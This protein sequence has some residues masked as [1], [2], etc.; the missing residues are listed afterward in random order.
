[1]VE[2]I[3]RFKWWLFALILLGSL[4]TYYER[5]RGHREHS[6]D[7]VIA[8]AAA[9]YGLDAALIK[10]VVWRESWFNPDARGT[11]GEL[12][13]MQL[14]QAA[15]AEWAGAE[16]LLW[17][18]HAQLLD[19]AKNTLAGTWYLRKQLRRFPQADNPIPYALAAYNAGPT[20]AQ[21]WSK[22]AA[23][24]NSAAFLRQIDFPGTKDY[25]L[26]VMR[27]QERY[28]RDFPA[29]TMKRENPPSPSKG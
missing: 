19:P 16:H 25:V 1:M 9:R 11:S 15:A 7:A 12:G 29:R 24:T 17:F 14:R 20:H 23:A 13:L 8:A 22:G 3:K 10:A 5:W 26:T 21:R 18:T 28:R 4:I 27:R 2:F 6:Q